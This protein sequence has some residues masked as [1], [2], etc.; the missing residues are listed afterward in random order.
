MPSLEVKAASPNISP[1]SN[2]PMV[3]SFPASSGRG[4][5]DLRVTRRIS[6]PVSGSKYMLASPKVLGGDALGYTL[7]PLQRKRCEEF[8]PGN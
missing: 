3:T 8:N 7:D 2:T 4:V 1:V 6:C 5:P